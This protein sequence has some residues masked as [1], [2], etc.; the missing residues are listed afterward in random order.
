MH[1][2]KSFAITTTSTSYS[3]HGCSYSTDIAPKRLMFNRQLLV[4]YFVSLPFY[5]SSQKKRLQY[6]ILWLGKAC[7]SVR[8]LSWR[9]TEATS[10][11]L[12]PLIYFSFVIVNFK[13]ILWDFSSITE[14]TM[15]VFVAPVNSKSRSM[16]FATQSLESQSLRQTCQMLLH[17][18]TKQQ[19]FPG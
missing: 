13:A 17:K 2:L 4:K 1:L 6:T 3:P 10:G 19:W 15:P 8:H 9:L 14:G 11:L 18:T 5:R 16:L 12:L 7:Y